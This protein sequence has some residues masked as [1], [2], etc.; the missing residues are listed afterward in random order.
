M[1]VVI[2]RYFENLLR[3]ITYSIYS[4]PYIDI[5]IA[6]SYQGKDNYDVAGFCTN[7]FSDRMEAILYL[8]KRTKHKLRALWLLPQGEQI[9]IENDGSNVQK[10]YQRFKRYLQNTEMY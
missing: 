6:K 5:Q 10:R 3:N 8:D 9:Y 4:K 7:K 2:F 1:L